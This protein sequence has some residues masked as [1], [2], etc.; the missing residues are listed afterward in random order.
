MSTSV[1][2]IPHGRA[3]FAPKAARAFKSFLVEGQ[4]PWR[5]KRWLW[6]H[7]LCTAI[8][9][10]IRLKYRAQTSDMYVIKDIFMRD[11]YHL[12]EIPLPANP[13]IFDVGGHIGAF[14]VRTAHSAPRGKVFTFEPMMANFELLSRNVKLNRLTN[15]EL[16]PLA[17]SG[18]DAKVRLFIDSENTAGHS[19][20]GAASA[21]YQVVRSISLDTVMT[22]QDVQRI[23]LLKMDCEGAEYDI[24]FATPAAQLSKI[25]RVVLEYHGHGVYNLADLCSYLKQAGLSFSVVLKEYNS[26]R[27]LAYF[28]RTPDLR[29]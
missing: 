25:D 20:I 9:G 6:R 18:S 15:V 2:Q 21:I 4:L 24:L 16:F 11:E 22:I 26:G 28:S 12:N 14:T 27:G 1:Q 29:M 13:V 5:A 3:A 19:I 7:C 17:M 10:D 23:D 8:I